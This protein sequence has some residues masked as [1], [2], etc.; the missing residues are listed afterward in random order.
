MAQKSNG[1]EKETNSAAEAKK[2]SSP[3]S[4]R[5]YFIPLLILALVMSLTYLPNFWWHIIM[6]ADYFL[7]W[8]AFSSRLVKSYHNYLMSRLPDR[9]EL[10]ANE[11][12]VSQATKEKVVELTKGYTV[13]LI[14]RNAMDVSVLNDWRDRDWWL[15]NFG[16]EE[17]LCKYVQDIALTNTNPSCT[18][19][20][21]LNISNDR[22]Y[23]SGE[24][25][26][27]VRRPE[28]GKMINTPFLDSIAPGPRVFTQVL[29]MHYSL[30][31][32][33]KSSY[34]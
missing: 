14:I 5:I 7:P 4:N 2:P 16:D 27:F 20:D 24:S 21:S 12:D 3:K 9:E 15:K 22:L 25:K 28:L 19:K 32:D 34:Y 23:I 8:K 18:I 30:I 17:V 33:P 11:I 29:N 26:L 1:T 6:L 10:P 31:I 13:P